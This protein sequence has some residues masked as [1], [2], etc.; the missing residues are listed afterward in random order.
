VV[1]EDLQ[2]DGL[3]VVHVAKAREEWVDVLGELLD[4]GQSSRNRFS[5]M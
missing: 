1:G 5:S 4:L 2:V 3:Q